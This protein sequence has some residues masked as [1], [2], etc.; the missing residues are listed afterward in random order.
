MPLSSGT[1]LGPYEITAPLGAG[2]MGEVYRARDSKLNR[3][4]ALK[5]LP[6]ALAND[7]ERMARFRREAQLLA[8]LNHPNIAAVYGIQDGAIVMELVEGKDL[9]GPMPLDEALPVAKQIAEALEAAH[10]KGVVHRDLKPANIKITRDGVVKVLDFGLARTD[11]DESSIDP[12]NS[13]TRT[14]AHT[15]AG[16]ILGTAAYMSPEQARGAV[17]DRRSDIWAFGAV[18][19][20]L[21]TGKQAF[22]GDTV[23]DTLA[24]VLKSEPDWR[25]LDAFPSRVVN[26]I[27]RCLVKERKQRLQWIG[28]ARFALDA[29][30]VAAI[31]TRTSRIHWL[32]WAI[33]GILTIALAGTLLTRRS[34]PADDSRV[35]RSH[36]LLPQGATVQLH[37]ALPGLPVISPDG[38]KIAFVLNMQSQPRMIWVRA[39]DSPTTRPLPGTE[40]AVL[41][42]WSPDGKW[43]GFFADG[44]LKKIEATGGL[45][46]RLASVFNGKGGAWNKQ[47]DIVYSA[48]SN[49]PLYRISEN[50]GEPVA[51]TELKKSEGEN[52]HRHPQF[53]PDGRQFLFFARTDGAAGDAFAGT[54][55]I[56]NLDG[57]IRKLMPS[58]SFGLF[59]SGQLLYVQGRTLMA[60]PFHVGSL[61]FTG[62]PYTVTND[63]GLAGPTNGLGIFTVSDN[64]LLAYMQG[65]ENE[66]DDLIWVGRDGKRLG[67][68]AP[69][70][71]NADQV[72][73]SPEGKRIVFSASVGKGNAEDI[74]LYD[75]ERGTRSRL[76]TGASGERDSIWSPDGKTIAYS[77]LQSGRRAPYLKSLQGD[78]TERLLL[79]FKEP[80]GPGSWSPDGRSLIMRGE[81]RDWLLPLEGNPPTPGKMIPFGQTAP[82]L[83]GCEFGPTAGWAVCTTGDSA[84]SEIYA[85]RTP[86]GARRVQVSA[87]SGILP[88]WR[89]KEIFYISADQKMMAVEVTVKNDDLELGPPKAIFDMPAAISQR[90]GYDVSP[91]GQRFLFQ[92]ATEDPGAAPIRL[93]QNWPAAKVQ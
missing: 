22:A 36:L 49:T 80:L 15:T 72:R 81:R 21:L 8:S 13:P 45:V 67:T 74:F 4:V 70:V 5:V 17:A 41:P 40:R 89:G 33:A 28:E 56:G 23:S 58:E 12:A 66:N 18:L 53:L 62:A 34:S 92:V 39:L 88:R 87:G 77:S 50:G 65:R 47:G 3:D 55:Q 6:A 27:R 73:L 82:T 84:P 48:G 91:D 32:P 52:S 57:K 20:E 60:R 90:A 11:A 78:G 35:I 51:V 59:A 75:I 79:D 69:I 63:A 25:A 71:Y 26:L 68:V 37:T 29:P 43:I 9:A 16:T 31:E 14:V 93:V 7:A 85:A 76:T 46:T 64:G 61:Q 42:F 86:D 19:Y 24:S 54:I 38:T 30:D 10:E 44:Q 1:Q 2:G 83:L